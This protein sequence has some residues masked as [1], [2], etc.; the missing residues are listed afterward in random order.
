MKNNINEFCTQFITNRD[1]LKKAVRFESSF[2]YP[3]AANKL[4]AAGVSVNAD[5]FKECKTILKKSISSASY[6]RGHSE[7]PI[8]TEMYLSGDPQGAAERIE[9][10]YSILKKHFSRS[11]YLAFLAI[12]V[13]NN[14]DARQSEEIGTRAKRLYD[15]MKKKHPFL[16]NS[17]DSTM[18]GFMAMSDKSDEQLI[19]DCEECF[20]IL[21]KT[22]SDKD[23]VQSCAQLFSITEGSNQEKARKMT[24]LYNTL[25]DA[26]RKFDKHYGLPVLAAVSICERDVKT[27]A[28]TMFEVDEFLS[29]QKG[30]G[31]LSTDKRTRLLHAAMLTLS[32]YCGSEN[33]QTSTLAMM[34]AQQAA[35]CAMI[36][37]VIAASN[38][39]AASSN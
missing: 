28:D 1:A 38:A 20:D 9:E 18:S 36:A 29:K 22:F 11:E 5:E 13:G 10:T 14:A 16:T 19:T 39:A 30:Y 17:A 26:G 24:K 35:E 4:T 32:F 34:A 27:I 3:A 25:K 7:L 37:C 12:L 21:K 33:S 23:A 8:L 31:I 6:L 2:I 15:M